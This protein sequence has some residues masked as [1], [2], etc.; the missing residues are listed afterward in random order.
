MTNVSWND[1]VDR[2][3]AA[4]TG[5][6]TGAR[7]GLIDING[8]SFFLKQGV[9]A[10]TCHWAQKEIAV[11]QLLEH[12]HWP[13]QPQ[14]VAI[15]PEHDGFVLPGLTEAAGWDW[16]DRWTP[17]RLRTTVHAMDQ[18]AA[19]YPSSSEQILLV[20]HLAD[21]DN[22]WVKL[23][24]DQ[25]KQTHL[26]SMLVAQGSDH[27]FNMQAEAQQSAAFT[28]R[29]SA[30]VHGDV[31][32]DNC[33]WNEEQ[34]QIALVDWNWA[35]LGDFRIDLAA[36]LVDVH[37]SGYNMLAEYGHRLDVTALHWLAG[38]WLFYASQPLWEGAPEHIRQFQLDRGICAWELAH[39]LS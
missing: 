27:R 39:C 14:L 33:G 32:S 19:I 4:V 16:S 7:R 34:Q 9:D 28:F 15:S 31:R 18:L 6:F 12:H 21:S 26:Q 2:P 38:Y 23:A 25:D 37:V 20:S 10:D 11:Y 35:H 8:Q 1:A 30:L 22:G 3:L 24:A 36:F 17:E 13:Y 5:G 29:N